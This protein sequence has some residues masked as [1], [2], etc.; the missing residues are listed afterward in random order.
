[1]KNLLDF[2]SFLIVLHSKPQKDRTS[3]LC[4]PFTPCTLF[5][6]LWLFSGLTVTADVLHA[7]LNFF[8]EISC[9]PAMKDW[10]GGADGNIFWPVLLTMLCNTPLHSP[11]S[12]SAFPQKYEVNKCSNVWNKNGDLVKKYPTFNT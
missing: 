5:I 6:P 2:L 10:L 3:G 11:I 1:M 8:T 12:L 9:R 7:V 4:M